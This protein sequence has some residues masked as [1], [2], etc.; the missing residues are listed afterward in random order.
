[1]QIFKL[2]SRKAESFLQQP[3]LKT[4]QKSKTVGT[5]TELQNYRTVWLY[6]GSTT[7]LQFSSISQLQ[8][9]Q[10]HLTLKERRKRLFHDYYG[11]ND[12]QI[13]TAR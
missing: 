4:R 8:T 12:G 7:K 13:D 2:C 1:M 10:K 5:G 3:G 6:R 11:E 9:I